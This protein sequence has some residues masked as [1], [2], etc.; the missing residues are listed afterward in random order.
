[1]HGGHTNGV[2]VAFEPQL[3]RLRGER[4]R[5]IQIQAQAFEPA[6]QRERPEVLA[7]RLD[8]EKLDHVQRIGQPALAIAA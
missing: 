8:V 7:D 4:A 2:L 3:G 5:H 6:H 1:M